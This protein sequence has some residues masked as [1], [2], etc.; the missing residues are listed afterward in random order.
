MFTM[1]LLHSSR[2]YD[3][4]HV[5]LLARRMACNAIAGWLSTSA[6]HD[7]PRGKG[8]AKSAPWCTFRYLVHQG[9]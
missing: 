5:L 8:G 1:S 6:A 9:A 7:D 4:T 2:N 3:H